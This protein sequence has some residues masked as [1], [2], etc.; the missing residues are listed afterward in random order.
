MYW[1][2][3][4]QTTW[5]RMVRE[6][7]PWWLYIKAG[8]DKTNTSESPPYGAG[9]QFAVLAYQFTGNRIYAEKAWAVFE[10]ELSS[11]HAPEGGR[12]VTREDFIAHVWMTDWLYPALTP[13]QR[14][15]CVDHLN[16]WGNLV[17]DKTSVRWGTRLS[18]SDETVGHYF[19]LAL[20]DVVTRDYN[21]RAG[22]FLTNTWLDGGVVSKPV[23]GLEAT[24]ADDSTM[25]N[26][27]KR[28]AELASGGEW[29]E[30]SAY[31]MGTLK[32][33]FAGVEGLRTAAGK[34]YFP[35]ITSQY[36]YFA[37]LHLNSY[38]PDL[39]NFQQWG[40]D[41]HHRHGAQA[42]PDF[43]PFHRIPFVLM[44][45]GINQG[46]TMGQYIHQ[47]GGELAT[48]HMGY[49]VDIRFIPLYNPY[50]PVAD[51]RN[52]PMPRGYTA[53][54]TGLSY[55]RDGWNPSGSFAA[56]MFPP[57]FRVDHPLLF[58]GFVTLYRK[59]EWAL[60]WVNAYGGCTENYNS[61]LIAGLGAMD[62]FRGP[63][64]QEFA[65][66]GSFG[67]VV[68][69]TGGQFNPSNYYNP[70][71]TYLHEYTRSVLY[72]PSSNQ[73]SD[74]MVLFDRV[75]ARDPKTL[76]LV[77]RYMSH[78]Q[79]RIKGASSLVQAVFH[80]PVAPSVETSSISWKTAK[81]QSV[82]VSTLF[83]SEL[84]YRT[85]DEMKDPSALCGYM[86]PENPNG[87]KRWQV[88]V[89]PRATSDW[90]TMLHVV[91]A[92]DSPG[93]VR[94]EPVTSEGGDAQGVVLH[95]A[96]M[97]DQ[98]AIFNAGQGR[99]LPPVLMDSTGRSKINPQ[100]KSIVEK[101][102][103]RATGFTFT[104]TAQTDRTELLLGDLD[105]ERLWSYSDNGGA[106]TTIE[107]SRQGFIK[108]FL[109]GRGTHTVALKV[110]GIAV[111]P[112]TAT[113]TP[114]RAPNANTATP[115]ATPLPDPG[116]G[117]K[118]GDSTGSCSFRSA[119][120]VN[121]VKSPGSGLL[122]GTTIVDVNK[123]GF[124]DIVNGAFGGFQGVSVALGNG[125]GTFRPTK[126]TSGI[127][128][129]SMAVADFTGD[130]IVDVIATSDYLSNNLAL[131]AGKPDGT[132]AAPST[133][134][135]AN[136]YKE[137]V[138]AADTNSDGTV[139]LLPLNDKGGWDVMLGNGNGTFKR[140]V[141]SYGRGTSKAGLGDF[142][143][144]RKIDLVTL[145]PKG[146]A[147]LHFGFGDGT[148]GDGVTSTIVQADGYTVGDLNRDGRSEL[149]ISNGSSFGNITIY[150]A[151]DDGRLSLLQQKFVRDRFFK[152]FV[153]D[154]S[155]D[156]LPDVAGMSF[157]KGALSVV[158]G[159]GS[160]SLTSTRTH[161][162]DPV[163]PEALAYGDLNSDGRKDLVVGSGQ[164]VAIY[165]GE[166]C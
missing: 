55:M 143:G 101:A 100:V 97:L 52:A 162:V 21:P 62:E 108:I 39:K 48:A 23:G 166:P 74:V 155:G 13:E 50:A 93:A 34:D 99:E 153:T 115:T 15:R 141:V 159:D 42:A 165:L 150:Q 54:G 87:E 53:T 35:E 78:D 145:S 28:F 29:I 128:I 19:G 20:V 49:S 67:Y 88:R 76:P 151:N 11:S 113:A 26:T 38:A 148:F 129:K 66:D 70:P 82:N 123:D 124:P 37:Q 10:K 92:F 18:D 104:F 86:D 43:W 146:Q 24:G 85:I 111:L 58:P 14:K 131:F 136:N 149:V 91:S 12:N 139:D 161:P 73:Q 5:N 60:N 17:L 83:P 96:G 56:A 2:P 72:L 69:A 94:Y 163:N 125:D 135:S 126:V 61:L 110:D 107:V 133:R 59:H 75:N 160:G 27:I 33:L 156:D 142:N 120:M 1:T 132:F 65:P 137:T 84:T 98:V 121:V 154:V 112:P 46:N 140:P 152:I 79:A 64:V 106:D 80:A 3:E 147:T 103:L 4:R 31:N 71:P 32:L 45:A 105:P 116:S 157:L 47:L 130:G 22:T 117:S 77:D 95:R 16:F 9:A 40:D 25:R 57:P 68:G 144:D 30:S 138:L 7:H 36:P 114:T 6:N 63:L 81:G 134:W 41:E 8:A 118:P 119:G 127:A 102:H 122:Q 44:L 89:S 158:F 90:T 164:A 109:V 51:W